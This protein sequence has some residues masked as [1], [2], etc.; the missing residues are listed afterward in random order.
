MIIRQLLVYQH[1]N[2]INWSLNQLAMF[3][4]IK[5][6]NIKKL[7]LARNAQ[8]IYSQGWGG[9]KCSCGGLIF[10]WIGGTAFDG[11]GIPLDGGGTPHPPP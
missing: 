2:V 4:F 10:F 6:I 5:D 8:K 3:L 11:G 9:Q 7:N 1:K